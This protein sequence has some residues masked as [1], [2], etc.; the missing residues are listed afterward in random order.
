MAQ[1]Q[2]EEREITELDLG[3]MLK[4]LCKVYLDVYEAI[5]SEILS[6][7]RFDENSDL[8]MTYLGKSDK[9]KKWQN[10]GRRIIPNIRTWVHIR[11]IIR[12]NRV[13]I[14]TRYRCK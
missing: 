10:E 3:V 14:A 12:W 1:K 2:K 5:Q 11:Q 13:S 9:V 8:S 7:T 4:I 6:T